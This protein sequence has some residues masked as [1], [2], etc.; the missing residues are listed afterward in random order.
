MILLA[1][2]T[3]TELA[4]EDSIFVRLAASCPADWRAYVEHDFVRQLA[5]ASLPEA[6]FRHY[7]GQDYLFLMHFARA[8]GLAAFKSDDLK[9]MRRAAAALDAL[10]NA[11]MRLHVKYCQ[12]WGLSEADMGALPEDP[13]NMAY[14]R[15]VLERGLAGDLLDLLVAL[16]P[17]VVGYGEIGL[18]LKADPATRLENNPYRDWI[19]TYAGADYQEVARGAVVQLDEVARRRI[20]E[21]PESSGRWP[22]L[23]ET[24]RAATRLEIGFWDMGL[25]PADG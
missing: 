8:Y 18:H 16:A 9:D 15:F 19:E 10:I 7:L 5:D 2:T 25:S 24:F 14:T 22:Q 20:G 23:A 12:G 6:C 4:P 21:D 17:C 13:R 11:E 1:V 3:P